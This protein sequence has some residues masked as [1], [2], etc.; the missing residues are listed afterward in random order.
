[1]ADEASSPDRKG[2]RIS[3]MS[4]VRAVDDESDVGGP[5]KCGHLF[6]EFYETKGIDPKTMIPDVDVKFKVYRVSDFDPLSSTF[7]VDFTLMLDWCDPSLEMAA[8]EK[9]PNFANHF[10][11]KCELMGQAASDNSSLDFN[12]YP[13]R[14]KPDKRGRYPTKSGMSDLCRHRATITMKV[15]RTLYA[16]LDFHEF[17]FDKQYLELSVKMLSVSIAGVINS[18]GGRP[19]IR[20]PT[21]WRG[22]SFG[23]ENGHELLSSADCLAE[24]DIL[25][26][27]SKAFSSKH[28]SIDRKNM[29]ALEKDKLDKDIAKKTYTQDQYTIQ[30][31]L[32]RESWSVLWN[33]VSQPVQP[34]RFESIYILDVF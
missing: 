6:R 33:M 29:N 3:R 23:K 4:T 17:P 18:S 32:C 27:S 24:F 22:K 16:R 7:F 10:W 26:L 15:R 13:P 9:L 34:S 31:C 25:R 2:S 21:R 20:H 19:T 5:G 30:M 12:E 8:G 1:M 11:P 14:Y 28:G